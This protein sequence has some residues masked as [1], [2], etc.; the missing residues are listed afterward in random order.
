M[1]LLLGRQLGTPSAFSA[2]SP[3]RSDARI[4]A[5]GN[6]RPFVLRQ[7][8]EDLQDQP[9][10][11]RTRINVVPGQRLEPNPPLGQIVRNL[12]QVLRIAAQAVEFPND[13][14]I[15][16]ATR[17]QRGGQRWPCRSRP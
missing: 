6:K 9:A 1:L 14:G 10:M 5:L 13:Q 4:D 12:N 11:G 16:L 7:H 17:P 8:G 15:A 2:T 3:G